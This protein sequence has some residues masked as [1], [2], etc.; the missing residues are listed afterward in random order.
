MFKSCHH[1]REG[2]IEER[3][4]SVGLPFAILPT[5]FCRSLKLNDPPTNTNPARRLQLA[6]LA[7][8]KKFGEMCDAKKNI[9]HVA[10]PVTEPQSQL[11]K[12]TSR[13]IVLERLVLGCGRR[14]F[15]SEV[16]AS[17]LEIL[18]GL[19]AIREKYRWSPFRGTCRSTWDLKV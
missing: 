18:A 11:A 16:S 19:I 12:Q 5:S 3:K 2:N 6:A 13:R 17:T 7:R 8:K 4:E 15:G 14:E 9:L 1:S 10:S